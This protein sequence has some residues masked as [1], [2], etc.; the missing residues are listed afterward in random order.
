VRVLHIAA[1]IAGQPA[2]LCRGL[3]AFGVEARS[4]ALH[5]SW[6]GYPSDVAVDGRGAAGLLRRLA[7]FI[8]HG[9]GLD[10]VHIHFGTTFL[11]RLLDV[12]LLARSG[13]RLVF[14][15]HGCEVRPRAETLA[16]HALS[17]CSECPVYCVPAKQERLLA[18]ARRFGALAL[19]STPDLRAAVPAAEH[20]PVAID[21]AEWDQLRVAAA[22]APGF[23]VLHAPS[24]P[25]I[26]GTRYVIAAVRELEARYPDV[27]LLLV[28]GEP[29]ARAR[30]RYGRATVAVDQLH[31][32]WYGLFAVE[33]MALMKPVL[34][35]IRSDLDR[36]EL[37][38]VRT[39][40]ERLAADLEALRG[41]P[42]RRAEMGAVG[43]AYVRAV[44]DLP[45]VSARLY[46]L[47]RSRVLDLPAPP[48]AG[49]GGRR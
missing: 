2:L 41:D 47:Y 28:Q 42:G 19:V 25:E 21:L 10:I 14:H 34:V 6:L 39:T 4:L 22:P 13:A 1:E 29:A 5:P 45:V 43:Y 20:L 46:E 17:A 31:L 35:A 7:A 11:P 16:R 24:D 15:F 30:L 40:R 3:R 37:P 32:G 49:R 36:P 8:R 48:A 38:V 12:P 9:R 33:A 23:V 26:K 44:H 27:E 18:Y